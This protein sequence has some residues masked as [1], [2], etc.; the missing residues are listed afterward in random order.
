MNRGLNEVRK[1]DDKTWRL[2]PFT[3]CTGRGKTT[4]PDGIVLSI[5]EKQ[6]RYQGGS[7]VAE[8]REVAMGQ[9]FSGH[10]EVWISF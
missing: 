4:E 1:Q 9:G 2:A 6:Q 3:A 7:V 10:V 5:S 8:V